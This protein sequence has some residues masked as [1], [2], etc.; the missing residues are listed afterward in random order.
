MYG[1]QHSGNEDY[2]LPERPRVSYLTHGEKTGMSL[3]DSKT[4]TGVNDPKANPSHYGDATAGN[5]IHQFAV[6]DDAP[7]LNQK[8]KPKLSR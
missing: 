2:I 1:G 7:D 6:C 4:G 8:V 5:C 3:C